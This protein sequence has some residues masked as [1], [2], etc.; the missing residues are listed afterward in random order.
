MDMLGV[1]LVSKIILAVVIAGSLIFL[2]LAGCS[3][4]TNLTSGVPWAKVSEENINKIFSLINLRKNSLIY[5]LGCGDGRVLFMAEKRGLRAIG[6]ELSLYPYLKAL[7]RKFISRSAVIVKRRDFFKVNLSQADAI[8]IFL[9][10]K[11]I[12]RVGWKL[13]S[14]LKKGSLV[15]SYCFAVP[16]WLPEKMI[17]TKPGLTYVYKIR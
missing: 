10:G 14:E 9:V 17:L 6:Y 4:Y 2:F 7:F 16:G 12:S 3:I 11:A 1:I 13:K 5:D 8:F 15:I